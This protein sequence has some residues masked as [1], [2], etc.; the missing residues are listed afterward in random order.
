MLGMSSNSQPTET[1]GS[2]EN[3]FK[4]IRKYSV[5]TLLSYVQ[6]KKIIPSTLLEFMWEATA[7]F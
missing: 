7:R 4:Y 5:E 3:D 1:T 6:V 2:G